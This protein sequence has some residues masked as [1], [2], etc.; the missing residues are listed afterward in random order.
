MTVLV[1]VVEK[2]SPTATNLPDVWCGLFN[3]FDGRGPSSPQIVGSFLFPSFG[4]W[5]LVLIGLV[6]SGHTLSFLRGACYI[7]RIVSI[8]VLR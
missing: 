2:A 8:R 7:L 1:G 3:A 6:L 5:G 4:V